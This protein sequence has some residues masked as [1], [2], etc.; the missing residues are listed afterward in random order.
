MN[1][2]MPIALAIDPVR[3]PET[4]PAAHPPDAPATPFVLF[5]IA[6]ATVWSTYEKTK[7]AV[8]VEGVSQYS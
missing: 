1:A 7:P 4:N 5:S 2:H 3:M 6:L 8:A